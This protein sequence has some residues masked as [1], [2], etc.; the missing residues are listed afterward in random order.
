MRHISELTER[1]FTLPTDSARLAGERIEQE[2]A[3][4]RLQIR[5]YTAPTD[6]GRATVC[7]LNGENTSTWADGTSVQYFKAEL[8]R[9][10]RQH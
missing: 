4:A 1:L 9:L 8:R 5:L 10:L 6:V 2:I 7:R 3:I